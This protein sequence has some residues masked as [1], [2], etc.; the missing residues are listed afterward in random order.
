MERVP[1]VPSQ[2]MFHISAHLAVVVKGP[3][4]RCHTLKAPL[5]TL[6]RKPAR[7]PSLSDGTLRFPVRVPPVFGSIVST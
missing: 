7:G 1:P 2:A 3:V 4:P 5:M 6:F